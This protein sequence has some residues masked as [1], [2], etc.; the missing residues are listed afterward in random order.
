MDR[1]RLA[2]LLDDPSSAVVRAATRALLPDAAGFPEEWL[3]IR[4]AQDRPRAVRVAA[5]RLLRAAG[6][7]RRPTS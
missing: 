3:R 2:P 6:L 1:E 4:T 5:R 7:H